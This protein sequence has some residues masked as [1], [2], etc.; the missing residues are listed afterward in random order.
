M[1]GKGLWIIREHWIFGLKTPLFHCI[2]DGVKNGLALHRAASALEIDLVCS[3]V[4]LSST[5]GSR[6]DRHLQFCVEY[7]KLCRETAV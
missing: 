3:T 7:A 6:E 5:L 4:H 2:T 1:C